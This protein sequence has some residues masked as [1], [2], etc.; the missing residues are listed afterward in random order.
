MKAVIGLLLGFLLISCSYHKMGKIERELWIQEIQAETEEL[1]K[2]EQWM[3]AEVLKEYVVLSWDSDSMATIVAT[4]DTEWVNLQ[5]I[6]KWT[7]PYS[8]FS[9]I[10]GIWRRR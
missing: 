1:R 4:N 6:K 10:N 9:I 7:R 3:E 5:R 8:G 2:Q